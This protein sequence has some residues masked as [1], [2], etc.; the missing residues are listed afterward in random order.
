VGEVQDCLIGGDDGGEGVLVGLER[1]VDVLFQEVMAQQPGGGGGDGASRVDDADVERE[2]AY[3]MALDCE[4]RLGSIVEHTE[5]L[6]RELGD[7]HTSKDGGGA[8]SADVGNGAGDV[9]KVVDVLNRQY[10]VLSG[11]EGRC[12]A[13]DRD[14]G[15]IGRVMDV[16]RG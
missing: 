8:S 2:K 14:L 12:K 4:M 5:D 16:G 11:L 15:W 3:S 7:L 9:G 13:T 1:Q 10:D 6:E